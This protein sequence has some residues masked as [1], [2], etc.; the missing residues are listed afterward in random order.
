MTNIA[1]AHIQELRIV[2]LE[3]NAQ[4]K[5]LEAEVA[6]LRA[7]NERLRDAAANLRWSLELA[8]GD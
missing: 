3:R 8:R 6:S 5:R 4:I 1:F 2:A 7:E